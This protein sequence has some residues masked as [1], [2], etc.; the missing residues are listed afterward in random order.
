MF[1]SHKNRPYPP[2]IRLATLAML[3]PLATMAIADDTDDSFAINAAIRDAI[4]RG[5]NEYVLPAGTY[6]VSRAILIPNGTRS[7]TLRGAGPKKTK[8]RTPSVAMGEVLRIGTQPILMGNGLSK[9]DSAYVFPVASGDRWIKPRG[10]SPTKLP[11]FKV[12]D[13]YVL[14]DTSS[15]AHATNGGRQLNHGEVVRITALDASRGVQI[16]VPASREYDSTAELT[17]VN[18]SACINVSVRDLS[19]DGNVD[20]SAGRSS[21]LISV[22]LGD[23]LSVSNVNLQYF[24]TRAMSTN[25]SRNVTIEDAIIEDGANPEAPGSG[26]GI[27][28]CR[29]RFVKVTD[30]LVKDTR[31]AFV[32]TNGATDVTFARCSAIGGG[33]FDTHGFDERRIT[34]TWCDADGGFA[35]GNGAWMGGGNGFFYDHCTSRFG[36]FCIGPNVRNLR[37][38]S[39]DFTNVAL[40]GRRSSANGFPASGYASDVTFLLCKFVDTTDLLRVVNDHLFGSITFDRCYLESTQVAWG[41]V[42]SLKDMEGDLKIT[43]SVLVSR[44]KWW[45]NPAIDVARTNLADFWKVGKINLELKNVR[46]FHSSGSPFGVKMSGNGLRASVK[47]TGSFFQ[48]KGAVKPEF[49]KNETAASAT[50]NSS[51]AQ[52]VSALGIPSG[53][54]GVSPKGTP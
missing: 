11:A 37:A 24:A 48:S 22:G 40:D 54:W 34:Y 45:Q 19:I 47:S 31:H 30:S 51:Y 2:L 17:N 35:A 4:A 33:N 29:S 52:S 6:N 18:S 43:N 7:F 36:S 26:Y 38:T 53:D 41:N 15:V 44:S 10:T 3:A 49:L 46:I 25:Y 39:C 16:D 27:T 1:I 32:A 21:N 9:E 28:I 42:L 8:I 50:S 14:R 13:Y 12:G 23:R 5:K 20:R